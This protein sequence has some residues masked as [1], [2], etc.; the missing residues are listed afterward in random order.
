M[1]GTERGEVI[2]Q[3]SLGSSQGEDRFTP[4]VVVG[5][6]ARRETIVGFDVYFSCLKI[7]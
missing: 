2:G 4:R 5:L 3:N 7:F 6:N 1:R